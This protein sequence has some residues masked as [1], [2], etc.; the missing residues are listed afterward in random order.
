MNL[1]TLIRQA[2]PDYI[3]ADSDK[4]TSAILERLQELPKTQRRK[5]SVK[6][7]VV[8]AAIFAMMLSALTVNAATG[9]KLF[10]AM[11]L[12]KENRHIANEP[13]Y[14]S[15]QEVPAATEIPV[16]EKRA[17]ISNIINE[18]QLQTILASSVTNFALEKNN[19]KFT[20]PE[21]LTGNGDFV[22]FTKTGETGWRLKRGE[23]LSIQ[24]NLDLTT[25]KYS[26]PIGEFMEVGYIKNGIPIKGLFNKAEEFSYTLT[27]DADGEYYFYTENLSAGKIIIATGNIK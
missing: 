24:F 21:I 9:G 20:I 19:G 15:M 26:D 6:I 11:L 22:I 18:D 10:G 5:I 7:A 1:E 23:K 12:N 17:L 2:K 3:Q 27:A 16:Y 4:V 14:A 25:N 13:N 8:A